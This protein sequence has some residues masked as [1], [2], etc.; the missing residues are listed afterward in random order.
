VKRAARTCDFLVFI[1]R[2]YVQITGRANYHQFSNLPTLGTVDLEANPDRASEPDIAAGIMVLGMRDGL[3]RGG[4]KLADYD[5]ATTWDATHARNIV[6]GDVATYGAAIREHAKKYKTALIQVL[7][8]D[9]SK[10]L[11]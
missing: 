7:K 1:G 9:E 11:V 5:L 10:A 2:G 8:L 6:N 4:H 3:F